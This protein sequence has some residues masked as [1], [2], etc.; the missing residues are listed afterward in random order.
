MYT[1]PKYN[2][3][4]LFILRFLYLFLVLIPERIVI[5]LFDLGTGNWYVCGCSHADIVRRNEGKKF[6]YVCGLCRFHASD[7]YGNAVYVQEFYYESSSQTAVKQTQ[8]LVRQILA[9]GALF[10][11]TERCT[12][13]YFCF[14]W[15]Y[16]NLKILND[17]GLLKRWRS[18]LFVF[19]HRFHKRRIAYV[20]SF[21]HGASVFQSGASSFNR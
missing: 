15:S 19:D 6:R 1:P 16:K 12:A 2:Q 13:V 8:L 4:C 17:V 5:E 20:C 3:N 21:K 9:L 10:S 7:P 11:V 18:I 14:G